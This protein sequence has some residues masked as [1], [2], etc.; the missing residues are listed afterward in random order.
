MNNV[1]LCCYCLEVIRPPLRLTTEH[2]IPLS[3]GGK[4]IKLNTRTCCDKCNTWRGNKDYERWLIEIRD[5]LN[6]EL[7]QYILSI[8]VE[9]IEY[10]IQYCEENRN[11]LIHDQRY[12]CCYCGEQ[13]TFLSQRTTE[14]L[15]PISKGGNSSTY[16]KRDC[17]ASC[18]HERGSKSLPYWLSELKEQHLH[19]K[20]INFDS[21]V[22]RI[23]AKIENVAYW[24]HY[25]ETAGVK[26]YRSEELY[27][28]HKK[29]A[30]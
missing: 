9:R 19:F 7:D 20:S 25:I 2:L 21:M 12:F 11:L 30:T 5:K 17:H 16:N 8:M 22:N 18:N 4:D 15:V 28:K 26:L 14:H 29:M 10:Y 13:I 27:Q 3:H 23:E 6:D 24:I 1:F